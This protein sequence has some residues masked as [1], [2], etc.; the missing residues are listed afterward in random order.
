M[1]GRTLIFLDLDDFLFLLGF[2]S[3]LL[4]FVFEFAEIEDFHHR[5][6][7]VRADLQQVEADRRR[8]A[9][10]PRGR[11]SRPAFR[12]PGRSVAPARRGCPRSRGARRELA[13]G[14]QGSWLWC[15]PVEVDRVTAARPY[16]GAIMRRMDAKCS[17]ILPRHSKRDKGCV[18]QPRR[19]R[20][21]RSGGVASAA[22]RAT[23][24]ASDSTSC[25]SPPRRRSATVRLS[26]SLRPT[27]AMHRNVL[28]AVLADLG[29][30]L[31]VA[32]VGLDDQP[33]RLAARQRPRRH[34]RRRRRR[35]WRPPPAP[36]RARAGSG[37]HSAR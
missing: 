29:V 32:Q 33:G 30:D 5:R 35:W 17:P 22:R 34:R 4:L 37:R 12:L 28:Q 10:S 13:R 27:T 11:S 16:G 20:Y 14:G 21:R 9:A 15:S 23:A 3:L 2:V 31:L 18:R 1:F 25:A 24:S 19:R 36:A 8:R 7:G 6:I 26:A